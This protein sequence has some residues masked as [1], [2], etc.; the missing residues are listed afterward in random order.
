MRSIITFL[1]NSSFIILGMMVALK[2]ISG[3][4]NFN[5]TVVIMLYMI[6]IQRIVGDFK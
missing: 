2:Y 1:F 3:G 6:I 5:E 4:F